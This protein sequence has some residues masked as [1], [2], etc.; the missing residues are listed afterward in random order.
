MPELPEVERAVVELRRH[1]VGRTILAVEIHHPSLRRRL[2]PKQRRALVGARIVGVRRRGKHQLIDLEDG[3]VLYAHFRMTGDWAAGS[4][5]ATARYPRAT[6]RLDDGSAVVLDDPR[7][8]STLVLREPGDNP[9]EAIGP[10]AD[11]PALAPAD[12]AAAFARRRA[13]IKQVLLDQSVLA[14]I[15]N[16]YASESLWR[17]RIDPR[18][19]ASSLH[20][21]EVARLLAAIRAVLRKASG[22]RYTDDGGRFDVYDREGRKCRRCGKPIVRMVQGGRSTYWCPNCQL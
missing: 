7:A 1:V 17:S 12:L 20:M 14:G 18:R 9:L 19:P 4:A 5:A 10:E 21:K 2:A 8:L 22:T 6:L 15:G 3:R 11:D 13:P 16:I